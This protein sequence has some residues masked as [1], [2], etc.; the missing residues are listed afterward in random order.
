MIKN[1]IFDF[2]QVM[3]RFDPAYMVSLRVTDPDDAVLLERVVFDRLYWDAL[4]AGAL[5]DAR[6]LEEIRGRLPRRLWQ[7]AEE[8]YVNWIYTLPEIEGMSD[9]VRRC[10]EVYGFRVFLLS[11]ISQYFAEHADEIPVLSQFEDCIYSAEWHLTK[12]DP[13]IFRL[14]C[15]RNGLREEETLFVD[16]SS[17]NIAGA[18][19]CGIHG[20]LFDGDV[21]RLDAFLAEIARKRGN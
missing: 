19:N 18:E 4:D 10:R 9:L 14:L 15:E 6:A 17:K 8:I 21:C 1:V 12:P 3:V 11:N 5:S 13:R 16:D 20:Y 2:G 7:V